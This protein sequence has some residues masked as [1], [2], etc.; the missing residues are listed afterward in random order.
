MGLVRFARTYRGA[1]VVFALARCL[2][3]RAAYAV[4]DW[5]FD[6]VGRQADSPFVRGVRA[7]LAVMHGL[8]PDHAD[9]DRLVGQ[10]LKNTGRGYVDFVRA[11]ARGREAVADCCR[12]SPTLHRDLGQAGAEKRGLVV[13]GAHTCSFD[14]EL[15]A[16]SHWYPDVLVLGQ[17]QPTG[18]SV[19]MNDMRQRL[20]VHVALVSPDALRDAMT[21]LRRGG[22]VGFAADVP[23]PNAEPITFFGKPACLPTGHAR[24]ALA[25]DAEIVLGVC[26]RDGPD[27]FEIVGELVPCPSAGL[28]HH[29][30]A[31]DWAQACLHRL[32]AVLRQWPDEW[33]MPLPLWEGLRAEGHP[34]KGSA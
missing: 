32:E 10:V 8:P 9:L 11:A 24:L 13:L 27:G 15:I 6:W 17:A 31:R 14:F 25:A 21:V 1:Q 33:V 22:M 29:Q 23:V 7:N 5:L 16:M 3:R 19:L 28:D 4:S 12:L 2:P 26:H 18:S 20:G 34:G 30:T